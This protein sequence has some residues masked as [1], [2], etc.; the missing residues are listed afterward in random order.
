MSDKENNGRWPGGKSQRI[1]S[2]TCGG[3]RTGKAPW[4]V[5]LFPVKR[6]RKKVLR[7]W[8]AKSRWI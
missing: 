4:R 3:F 5:G 2:G 7:I 6:G 1:S 8:A